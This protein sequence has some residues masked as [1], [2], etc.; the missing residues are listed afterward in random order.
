MLQRDRIQV[1]F[2]AWNE[3]TVPANYLRDYTT[4]AVVKLALK[5]GTFVMGTVGAAQVPQALR[6]QA[7]VAAS[8]DKPSG[9]AERVVP[10]RHHN[11][12]L[13]FVLG[14]EEDVP[15]CT[16]AV[17]AGKRT[18]PVLGDTAVE[19]TPVAA[20]LAA[21]GCGEGASIGATPSCCVLCS[22]LVGWQM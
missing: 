19:P 12:P 5:G 15:V 16:I 2:G 21:N 20:V 17:S 13:W 7:A 1:N 18:G 11:I 10:R 3:K 14:R 9:V 4:G 8:A 22:F 6:M